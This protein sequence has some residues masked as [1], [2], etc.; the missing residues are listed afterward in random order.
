MNNINNFEM[1]LDLC[2]RTMHLLLLAKYVLDIK[3]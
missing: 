3:V 2:K 1:I